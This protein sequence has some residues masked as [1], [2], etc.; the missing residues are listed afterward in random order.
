MRKETLKYA[1]LQ[2]PEKKQ[3]VDAKAITNLSKN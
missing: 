3:P 1:V 2:L